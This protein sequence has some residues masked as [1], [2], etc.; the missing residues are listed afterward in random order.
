[1]LR[2][3]SIDRIS[4][5]EHAAFQRWI[6]GESDGFS[7]SNTSKVNES[8]G[9]YSFGADVTEFESSKSSD[10]ADDSVGFASGVAG[11]WEVGAFCTFHVGKFA[12]LS[13]RIC[14]G[15]DQAAIEIVQAVVDLART[16]QVEL[17]QFI[18]REE[19]ASDEVGAA[20]VM[21]CLGQAGLRPLTHLW[22]MN[23]DLWHSGRNKVRD[24]LVEHRD[25]DLAQSIE[26]R[27]AASNQLIDLASLTEKT[28]Q[29]TLDCAELDGV[30]S[31]QETLVGYR[32]SSNSQQ[33]DW[34]I[35]TIGQEDVGCV[36]LSDIGFDVWELTYM[37]VVPEFRGRGIGTAILRHAIDECLSKHAQ[38][39]TLAVDSRNEPAIE[40][41]QRHGFTVLGNMQAWYWHPRL[42]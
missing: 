24:E 16:R 35:A 9:Q 33:R 8:I 4:P 23:L 31:T 7:I 41:Y 10:H 40:M 12:I 28:Y 3:Y 1:M 17:L 2:S 18:L 30:R 14:S 34:W 32:D 22:R 39:L 19:D 36:Y 11:N 13:V 6:R 42:Q 20:R 26:F 37:G 29:G 5:S 25:K 21:S 27:S 15:G 38:H